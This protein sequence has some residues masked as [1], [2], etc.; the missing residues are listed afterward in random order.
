MKYFLGVISGVVF[1][2]AIYDVMLNESQVLDPSG[3][4]SIKCQR[5]CK[6][7]NMKVLAVDP[8]D[9]LNCA[10]RDK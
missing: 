6:K 9:N 1:G 8:Q 4:R 7:H 5:I 10:C 2:L 3:I